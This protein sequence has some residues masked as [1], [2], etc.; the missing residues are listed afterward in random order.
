[1][2][3]RLPG[4]LL[5][6]HLRGAGV[7]EGRAKGKGRRMELRNEHKEAELDTYRREV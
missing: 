7:L 2:L 6:L 1:M 5:G 4:Y 3:R